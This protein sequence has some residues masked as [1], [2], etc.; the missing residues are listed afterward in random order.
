MAIDSGWEVV[1][2]DGTVRGTP[3]R[4]HANA[5]TAAAELSEAHGED[6]HP[7]GWTLPRC[8]QGVHTVQKA[9]PGGPRMPPA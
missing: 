1:C 2:P 7:K 4:H 5:S 3:F 6:R 9:A 8:P